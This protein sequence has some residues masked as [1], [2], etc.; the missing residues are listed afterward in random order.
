MRPERVVPPGL[1]TLDV[2]NGTCYRPKRSSYLY[3]TP[4]VLLKHHAVLIND[5]SSLADTKGPHNAPP[6]QA[7]HD[8]A[9]T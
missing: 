6:K 7:E 3:F 5:G 9:E 1:D 4:V 2:L 8:V